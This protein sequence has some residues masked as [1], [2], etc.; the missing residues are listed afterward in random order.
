LVDKTG[1]Y[2]NSKQARNLF[3]P[4]TLPDESISDILEKRIELLEQMMV[5]TE[6][7]LYNHTNRA[8]KYI[9]DTQQTLF[10][11]VAKCQYL[12]IS[13]GTA[14]TLMPQGKYNWKTCYNKAIEEMADLVFAKKIIN[15]RTISEWNI[16]F[17]QN[18]Y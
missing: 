13:Y 4:N 11:L 15:S 2:F 17:R 16:Y 12:R 9:P 1:D 10:G 7:V 5:C 14:L 18:E 3:I 6:Q 8:N